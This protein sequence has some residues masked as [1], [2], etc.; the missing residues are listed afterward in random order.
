MPKRLSPDEAVREIAKRASG[1][2][3]VFIPGGAAEP[4]AL[5][6][7]WARAPDT[8]ADLLFCGVFL[9]G[10][11]AFDYSTLHPSAELDLFLMTQD[12]RDAV[13]QKRATI[14]P[15]HYSNVAKLIAA[16]TFSVA[17]LHVGKPDGDKRAS[18]GLAAD[19]APSLVGRA[20]YTIAL[21]NKTMPTTEDA[22]SFPIAAADAIVEADAPLAAMPAFTAPKGAQAIADR[23][24]ALVFDDDVVQMGVGRLPTAIVA[25][26]AKKERLQILSGMV[27]DSILPLLDAGAVLDA[28]G[29]ITTGMVVGT[30]R[31]YERMGR[32]RRL[33]LA[34]VTHT[35]A[36]S[37][38]S[39]IEKFVSINACLEVDL[40]G[41]INAEFAGAQQIASVGGMVDYIRAARAAPGG[42]A[43]VALQAEGKGG[44]SR[45]VPRLSEGAVTVTRAD[46]PIII[47]EHGAVDLNGLDMDARA[48]ALAGIAAPAHRGV[49][50][51]AWRAMRKKF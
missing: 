37:V 20:D 16:R 50:S 48:E 24:A 21:V 36:H 4:I 7:A 33:K 26:L 43:I 11:N 15:A 14:T 44:E 51:E 34:P 13:K 25:A 6:D 45:I 39:R 23:V 5:R 9:P 29:A 41:Q 42:R 31:L 19:F 18:F 28:P 27:S 10:V 49:L 17:I 2:K 3:R 46:A 47:T 1:E 32:E 22:P 8:A 40:F 35:H 30:E 38:L 12:L